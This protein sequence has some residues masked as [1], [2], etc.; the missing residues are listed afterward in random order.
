M[1]SYEALADLDIPFSDLFVLASWEYKHEHH[2]KGLVKQSVLNFAST[3]SMKNTNNNRV[4][5]T[6]AE[7]SNLKGAM[8]YLL[9]NAELFTVAQFLHCMIPSQ[10]IFGELMMIVHK[11]KFQEIVN[12]INRE[13]E[14]VKRNLALQQDQLNQLN[15]IKNNHDSLMSKDKEQILTAQNELQAKHQQLNNLERALREAEMILNKKQADLDSRSRFQSNPLNSSIDSNT[16]PELKA[17]LKQ[18]NSN[19]KKAKVSGIK[20]NPPCYNAKTHLSIRSYG[21]RDFKQWAGTHDFE[22]FCYCILI[23]IDQVNRIFCFWREI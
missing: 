10:L 12:Q 18:L 14:Q 8:N 5:A 2:Y 17:I 21:Q 4:G 23:Q 20:I 22:A 6:N 11:D 13:S 1:S 16:D 15:N 7:L 3:I 19:M 9:S